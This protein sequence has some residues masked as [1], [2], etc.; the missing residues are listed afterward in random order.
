MIAKSPTAFRCMQ[1]RG[2]ELA[3]L[4]W[5]IKRKDE[6]LEKHPLI[7]MMTEFGPESNWGEAIGSTEFDRLSFGAAFWLRDH[8]QLKR[9]NPDTIDVKYD[10]GGITAFIQEIDGKVVN[11]F[12]RD[13]IIYFREYHPEQ[14][15]DFGLPV[16]EILKKSVNAEVETLLMIEAY[17]KNDA[18]P[19]FLLTTDQDISEKEAN[20]VRDWWN[21]LFRGSRRAG[22]MGIAGKG[23]KPVPVGSSMAENA[24]LD[25]LGSAQNDI[26]VAMGIPRVLV[27]QEADATYVNLAESRKFLIED[28]IMPRA[29]EYQNVINQDLVQKTYPD[30][31]FEFAFDEM[32][33]LQEDATNKHLRL[34]G[35]VSM[36]LISDDY[37]REEM[38]YP[39]QA[40]PSDQE[41]K[42][43][44]EKQEA[45]EG[46][47][48]KKAVKALLKGESPSVPFETDNISIDRQYVIRGRLMNADSE[49]AVRACFQ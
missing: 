10:R 30:V 6:I 39:E 33:I 45:A 2:Q 35:A 29:M 13:E 8:D 16:M 11:K 1:M 49:E 48:E 32:Q 34:S 3:N 37:Y 26:C 4:P 31:M 27:G 14:E 24:I 38:G 5:H 7:D 19:G 18:I 41:A 43:K 17:F 20:R 9:L 12:K 21:K 36:G 40:K 44:A 25:I 42:A 46:K 22:K 28:T 47:W 15:L 23:L